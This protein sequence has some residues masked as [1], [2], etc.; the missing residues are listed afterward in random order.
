MDVWEELLSGLRPPRI[1]TIIGGG[2]KT[3]LMYYLQTA[4][5]LAGRTAI[6]ATTTKLRRDPACRYAAITSLAEGVAAVEAALR[7]HERITLVAGVAAEDSAK[8]AGVPPEWI[9]CLA[10]GFSDTV[11]LNEGDGSAGRPLKGHLAYEPVI[12]AASGLVIAVVGVDALG[13]PLAIAAHRP[14]RAAELTRAQPDSPVNVALAARLLLH[15]EGYLRQCPPASRVVFFIN[16]VESAGQDQQA[17]ELATAIL[18][19][20]HPR[21]DAVVI[22]SVCR[23]E[24]RQVVAE[25]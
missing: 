17:R 13:A 2:G 9:D 24:F 12:P 25:P 22:G 6:A 18:A 8:M 14:E 19:G 4:W 16:K 3:G 1:V 20:G 5:G 15:P 23:R 11:F 7:Q 21:V 10:A